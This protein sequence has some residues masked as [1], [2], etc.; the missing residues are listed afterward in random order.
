M[1][2]R[3]ALKEG[4]VLEFN[5]NGGIYKYT[6]TNEIGRGGLSI[7]YNAEYTN[8]VGNNKIVRIKECYPFKLS[9]LRE[10]TGILKP[11]NSS[12]DE[13]ESYKSSFVEDFKKFDSMS[14]E[15]GLVN[16]LYA[17][18]DIYSLN[19]T[20][21]VV[22]VYSEGDTLKV[23][24]N[25]S[26][27]DTISLMI[28]I[29]KTIKKIHDKGYLYLDLK[30]D[31]VFVLDEVTDLVKLFDFDSLIKISDVGK[32]GGPAR[33]SYTRGF[34]AP[35]VIDDAGK[36]GVHTDVYAI[37][38]M[39]YYMMFGVTATSFD[40]ERNATFDYGQMLYDMTDYP[41]EL[42][43]LTTGFF[44]RTIVNYTPDRYSSVDDVI[45]SLLEIRNFADLNRPY[46]VSCGL[47]MDKEIYGREDDILR[48]KALITDNDSPSFVT[49]IGGIGK[50]TIVRKC[51]L[52]LAD[53][54]DSI[55]YA[56]Q[57]GSIIDTIANDNQVK[58]NGLYKLPEESVSDY[59]D[60]KIN[61][62][63]DSLR[64]KKVLFVL[65]DF[66]G[67]LGDD[68]Y[69]LIR[70]P[71]KFVF[72]TRSKCIG[73]EYS[74]VVIKEISDEDALIAVL[75][76]SALRLFDTDE[77][78]YAKDI[79]EF[80][81]FHT[82]LIELVGKQIAN[83][84]LSVKEA[85]DMISKRGVS[86]IAPEKINYT[87]DSG[88]SY[89]SI[90]D[91]INSLV[92]NAIIYGVER[93]EIKALSVIND[94]WI[95]VNLFSDMIGLGNKDSINTLRR[96]G[97]IENYDNMISLH[98]II[99]EMALGWEW[100]DKSI[101]YLKKMLCYVCENIKTNSRDT[102]FPISI[103]NN[104]IKPEGMLELLK[105][106]ASKATNGIYIDRVN[107][108]IRTHK[109]D[110]VELYKWLSFSESI[111]K[112]CNKVSEIRDSDIYLDVL[113]NTVYNMPADKDYY[114][115]EH[116]DEVLTTEKVVDSICLIKLC[117]YTAH[118]YE[119]AADY[120]NA[121]K[122][123]LIADD[124]SYKAKYN[125][126]YLRAIYYEMAGDY[127]DYVLNGAYYSDDN[128]AAEYNKKLNKYN[129][130]AIY[131][132]RKSNNANAKQAL[133]RYLIGRTMLNIRNNKVNV[134][135]AVKSLREAEELCRDYIS[136][137]SEIQLGMDMVKCWYYTVVEP[138]AYVVKDI[139]E[140][141]IKKAYSIY[142][143]D[144]SIIDEV[145]IPIANTL[146]ELLKLDDSIAYLYEAIKICDEHDGELPYIRMKGNL[147]KYMCD[148]MIEYKDDDKRDE[149]IYEINEYNEVL[150]R[151]NLDLINL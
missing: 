23:D 67:E 100:D 79:I 16:S 59:A 135:R 131:H 109:S 107:E 47:T 94:K 76:E 55:V 68:Y 91:V 60:R 98:P 43:S 121:Y 28:T 140:S 7:V 115:F 62:L 11:L 61:T 143:S 17:T 36:I 15:E 95:D 133:A 12:E 126:H 123:I 8:N 93:S 5:N 81:H 105:Y 6:V 128:K 9:L 103:F 24:S 14:G 77:I 139:A 117:D 150:K 49:G 137:Y 27:K 32:L 110:L 148:V 125:R 30:P 119:C 89:S 53:R 26:L 82:L 132:M 10:D 97:Y 38:A 141:A 138:D 69:K 104:E 2:R 114:V 73:D 83:S 101:S 66:D 96:V 54:Y 113:Y 20:Y 99:K 64:D 52:D 74:S 58:V 124:I 120:D 46:I 1:D 80:C 127:Y 34:Q 88:I 142:N 13:F 84:F 85:R 56:Y 71:F 21:Y 75:Q 136:P 118:L 147:Y 18:F 102:E 129:D 44:R 57:R 19:N 39:F 108:N 122:Y 40:C 146:Y 3:I 22:S 31:N 63:L 25:R 134:G 87:K 35:E 145:Y 78:E 86:D 37:G 116:V 65:D 51:V 106:S 33:I 111:L 42:Y 130:K 90:I 4:T 48:V 45:K 70:L 151:Y 72:V 149:F 112:E 92:D 144:L 50:S 41:E 29:S